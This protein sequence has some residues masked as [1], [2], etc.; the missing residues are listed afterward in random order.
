MDDGTTRRAL[1]R[2]LAA[3]PVAQAVPAWAEQA[4][5]RAGLVTANVCIL[6][7]ETTAGPFYLDPHLVRSAIDEGRPGV[8][9]AL[10]LQV[11]RADCAPVAGA[12]VD[13]WHCDA[14][15]NY[16]GF[17]AQ[18]SDR[19]AST[20][21]ET[22]LRG[23]QFSDAG[24]VVRFQTIYP[25]WYR[26]RTVHIHQRIFL[27]DRTVLTSQVFFPEAASAAVFATPAYAARAQAQDTHN[28]NDGVA[29]SVGAAGIAQVSKQGGGLAAALVV[30]IA[31]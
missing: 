18:G 27:D 15:G 10:T 5:G 11:V 12:R 30:G 1:L 21:G 9:L 17:A 29:R 20:R 23:T 16:S 6:T 31:D 14:A 19:T 25:G 13:V 7:P 4:A 24:G 22:F 8:P 3:L 26:G 28:D 2:M